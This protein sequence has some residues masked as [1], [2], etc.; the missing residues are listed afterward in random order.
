MITFSLLG[1]LGRLGN[2]MFQY[3]ALVGLANK[4]NV[5]YGINYS[6]GN[7]IKWCD[8]SDDREIN[9][10]TLTINKGFHNLKAKNISSHIFLDSPIY[11]NNT[12]YEDEY[13]H[14][15]EE[16]FKLPDRIN[17]IGY[18]QSEK[19]FKHCKIGII[20]QYQFKPEIVDIVKKYLF[21]FSEEL[22]AVHIRRTD[23][24]YLNIK[25]Y[26]D[27]EYIINMAKTYFSDK[28][29][30]FVLFSDDPT[31]INNTYRG[32]KFCGNEV[33]IPN[34]N[35]QYLDMCC[36]SLC[37]HNVLSKSTFAWWGAYLNNNPN[38]IVVGPKQWYDN[39]SEKILADGWI[40]HS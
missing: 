34:F 35:N 22:V 24:I 7:N 38:K 17:I 5:D 31:F 30:R 28:K 23:Y 6:I 27:H 15:S 10:P 36:M 26:F 1:R 13:H 32:E 12:F 4:L 39:C 40:E 3:A 18:F 11:S 21:A 19:Y 20:H 14:F 37:H 33:I 9:Y 16:F 29:Y 2:Q 8:W 25:P